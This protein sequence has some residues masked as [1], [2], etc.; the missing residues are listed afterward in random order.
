VSLAVA[1]PLGVASAAVYGTSIVVQHRASHTGG[2]ED[3]RHLMSLLRNP[4]WLVAIAGDFVGFLLNIAALSTGPVVVIQPLVVLMLPIALV[5]GW[6]LGGPRPRTGE[7][8]GSAGIIL[9]LASFLALV[10]KPGEGH[11]PQARYIALTIAIVLLVGALI[12]V[13][14]LKR[15]ATLRGSV[16]GAAAG[17]YF[18]TLGVMVDGASNVVAKHGVG[19]LFTTWRGLDPL[20]GII[21]LGTGGIILTQVSF[22]I[23]HLAATLPANLAADPVTAVL[24]GALLL[25]EH[26]PLGPG[27]L[28]G[29]IACLALV[30]AG[31]MRLARRADKAARAM[32]AAEAAAR[33]SG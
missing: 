27:Y 29:Y 3:A 5:V 1:I 26:I 10:G 2:D 15:G 20:L 13:S 11:T 23:G 9:G 25:H 4:T 19:A 32:A 12:S 14:V 17:I 21:V 6:R 28:C 22:Q 8:L 24:I 18:G 31:T 33:M 16:Y 30:I 7:W